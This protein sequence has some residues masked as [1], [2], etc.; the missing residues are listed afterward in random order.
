MPASTNRRGLMTGKEL[1]FTA[2]D[3]LLRLDPT[4]SVERLCQRCRDLIGGVALNLIS[5]NH[6]NE[7]SVTHQSEGGR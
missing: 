7:L 6:M 1:S 4:E 5:M 2:S 3:R